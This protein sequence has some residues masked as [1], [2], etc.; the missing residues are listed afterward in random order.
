MLHEINFNRDVRPFLSDNCFVCHGPDTNGRQAG[1]RLDVA[2]GIFEELDSGLTAIDS[3]DLKQSELLRRIESSDEFEKMPPLESGKS[4][5]DEEKLILKAWVLQGAPYEKHWSFVHPQRPLLPK[6]SDD[7]WCRNEID[8]FVLSQLEE[9][10]I[11][12]SP[13]ADR[14]TLLRRVSFDLTGLPPSLEELEEFLQDTSLDAYE[15]A[16]DRLLAS[17]RHGEMMA[18]HWLDLARYADTDGYEKDSHR[19]MWPYR[20]WVIEAFNSNMRFDQFTREQIAGDLIA[21]ASRDQLIASG[22]NRNGPTTSESGS[23]PA[24]YAAKYAV[25]RTNTTS[26]VWLALT[27]QCAEC[28]DHKYDPISIQDYYRMFAFFDQVPEDPLYEGADSPPSIFVFT[29]EEQAKVDELERRISILNEELDS[30]QSTVDISQES[31]AITKSG[32]AE[33]SSRAEELQEELESFKAE[34]KAL[35]D[36][37]PVVRIMQDVSPR[38]PTYV[39]ESGDFRSLGEQVGPGTPEVL[40]NLSQQKDRL[41]LAEWLTSDDNPLTSRV[42][43]NRYW[44]IFFGKGIVRTMDDFGMQGEWP[45][46]PELLDWLAVEFQ[47]RDWDLRAMIR[48]FVTSSSYRQSSRVRTE[49]VEIDPENRLLARFSRRRMP[50]EMIRDNALYVSGLLHEQIGG[51]SVF[52]YHPAGLWEEVAWADTPWKSW[53]QDEGEKLYRRSL[54]TFWKRSLHHPVMAVFDAPSRTVCAIERPSTNTP[55]QAFVTLNETG[56]VE[57]ARVL[58][59]GVLTQFPEENVHEGIEY[60]Y[61][62]VL[63]RSPSESE[64]KE[65]CLLLGRMIDHY[66]SEQGSARQLLEVGDTPFNDDIDEVSLASWT[67]IAQVILNL[68]ESLSIE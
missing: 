52:P 65:L 40:G 25:D 64:R 28:H 68:D 4:L 8:R 63:A 35:K 33:I 60:M 26:A 55:L 44:A 11:K 37:A 12:P 30:L 2:E 47:H 51:A 7:S 9:R 62:T 18:M 17:P 59:E 29:S 57:A 5:S 67:S 49:L 20:D 14:A 66:Q 22:F 23:D 36:Q 34:L 50:A 42:I 61:W 15:Q 48:M 16:V 41:G 32:T 3:D 19:R 53:N 45:S 39:L 1:L 27:M 31:T 6:V 43:M 24:E 38:R 46:H 13:E 10:D 56:F 58:A 54:Y 21:G